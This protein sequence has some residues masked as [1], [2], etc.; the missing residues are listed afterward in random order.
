MPHFNA[1]Y[2]REVE[3]YEPR[4]I[5][6][7][8]EQ[9]LQLSCLFCAE[10]RRVRK[11]FASRKAVMVH[12]A[13]HDYHSGNLK[14]LQPTQS[15]MALLHPQVAKLVLKSLYFSL[16]TSLRQR[17]HPRTGAVRM[18]GRASA[19]VCCHP[20]TFRAVLDS[21]YLSFKYT[22]TGN[23]IVRPLTLVIL[24]RGFG[25]HSTEW[26]SRASPQ[27]KLFD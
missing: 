9:K 20:I 22:A 27:G 16:I 6:C 4:F 10:V 3:G 11:E 15:T 18:D 25:A 5:L 21:F 1:F 24:Q 14:M 2:T 13:S 23:I 19:S 12:A 8:D 17:R 7:H 26:C